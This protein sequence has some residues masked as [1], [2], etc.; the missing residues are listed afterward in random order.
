MTMGFQEAMDLVEYRYS[1]PELPDFHNRRTAWLLE[2]TGLKTAPR[3]TVAGSM[4]KASTA[5]LL[6]YVLRAL[7]DTVV[8]GTKPPVLETHEGNLERYQWLTGPSAGGGG[9]CR[10]LEPER[11]AEYV[12]ELEPHLEHLPPGLGPWAPYDLRAWVLARMGSESGV[13]WLIQEANIGLRLDP[14]RAFGPPELLLLTRIGEEHYELLPA[15]PELAASP[16]LHPPPPPSMGGLGRRA[17]PVWH[18][19]GGAWPGVRVVLG[20]QDANVEAAC[21]ELLDGSVARFGRDYWVDPIDSGL[22]GSSGR[23]HLFGQEL[24]IRLR[25]LG[26]FQLDNAAQAAAAAWLLRPEPATLDAIV[27]GLAEA[28]SPGRLELLGDQN[29][30]TLITVDGGTT[31]M[32]AAVHALEELIPEGGTWVGLGTVMQRLP[33]PRDTLKALLSS[34]R[35]RV[36]VAT[37]YQGDTI[38]P[39]VPADQLAD[40]ARELRPDIQVLAN[41]DPAQA[42]REARA[43]A[44]PRELVL[45]IG[46]GL[47]QALSLHRNQS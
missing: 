30:P 40:W 11:F 25:L 20:H 3:V 1:F 47:G 38:S 35:L 41:R 9:D 34:P 7:G 44:G 28:T 6:A 27:T 19:A 10:W 42:L 45:A 17:G 16:L 32:A 2:R 4:G 29:P 15:P 37:D 36:F 46:P 8:L 31:K 23:L 21:L 33:S 43:L 22:A 18:K 13:D 39:D 26:R 14:T 12:A 5:R 24:D